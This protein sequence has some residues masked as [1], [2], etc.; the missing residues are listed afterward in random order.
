MSASEIKHSIGTNIFVFRRAEY[1]GI[2][3]AGY[4][5]YRSSSF[6]IEILNTHSKFS[7]N[8]QDISKKISA[9]EFQIKILRCQ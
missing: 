2:N 3:T 1:S 6:I 7:F 5:L 8:Y 4:P 9:S